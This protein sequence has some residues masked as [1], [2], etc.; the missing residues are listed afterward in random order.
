M[1]DNKINEGASWSSG[2]PS[3]KWKA[4]FTSFQEKWTK[5]FPWARQENDFD[6]YC[7]FCK[8]TFSVKYDGVKAM[9]RHASSKK[10]LSF[11]TAVKRNT[12]IATFFVKKSCPEED[13][14]AAVTLAKIY[15]SIMHHHSYNNFDCDMKLNAA[16]F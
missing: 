10:H 12:T 11:D 15:H 16:C 3:R 9:N 7:K 4:Y 1:S 5:D 6:V 13:K 14:I 2:S 8:V